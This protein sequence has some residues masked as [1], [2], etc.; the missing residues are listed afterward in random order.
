MGHLQIKDVSKIYTKHNQKIEALKHIQCDIQDHKIIGLFGANGAGKSTLMRTIANRQLASAGEIYLDGALLSDLKNQH[1]V[2]M[3]GEEDF[4]FINLSVKEMLAMASGYYPDYNYD[5][6]KELLNKIQ[7][8]PRKNFGRLSKGQKGILMTIIGL[9]SGAPLTLMD[10]TF[11]SV[12][13]QTRQMIFETLLACYSDSQRSFILTTHHINEVS[14]LLEEV[15][16][17]DQGEILLHEAMNDIAEKA[18]IITGNYEKGK[19]ILNQSRIL[20]IQHFGGHGQFFIFQTLTDNQ[21]KALKQNGLDRVAMPLEQLTVS[22][23]R[24]GQARCQE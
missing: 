6:E 12:D 5:L 11:T 23:T 10:E 15:I 3:V 22:L 7:L 24:G 18:W 1:Q 14:H 17:M 8:S 9:C 2:C 19:A 13:A 20:D 21:V 16:I 4:K